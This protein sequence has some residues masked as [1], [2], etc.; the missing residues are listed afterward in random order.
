MY[1]S[2]SIIERKTDYYHRLRQ[3]TEKG[4]WEPWTHYIL[5]AVEESASFTRDRILGIRDLMQET[6]EK[7]RNELPGRVYSKELIDVLF[8]HPFRLYDLL[9]H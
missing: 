7:T 4:E 8:S 5:E 1:L 3:V 6:M 2:K 9:S